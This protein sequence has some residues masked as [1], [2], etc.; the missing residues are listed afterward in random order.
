MWQAIKCIFNFH[1]MDW[2]SVDVLKQGMYE[3]A[4]SREVCKA[5]GTKTEWQYYTT[6]GP[7]SFKVN[8]TPPKA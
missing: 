1:D 4:K 5:C 3:T 2:E 6:F 7:C 8:L